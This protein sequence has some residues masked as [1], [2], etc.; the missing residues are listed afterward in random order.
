MEIT[1][2]QTVL[3]SERCDALVL[4]F[5]KEEFALGIRGNERLKKVCSGF[6]ATKDF[7][8]NLNETALLYTQEALAAKRILFVGLGEV[9][10]Y[11]F[12]K[13][14]QAAG[15]AAKTLMELGVKRLALAVESLVLDKSN[16]EEAAQAAVEGVV[17]ATYQYTNFKEIKPEDEK[18]VH[19]VAYVVESP[20]IVQ[21]VQQGI[22]RGQIVANAANFARDLQNHP[23]NWATP[24]RLAEIAQSTAQEVG[25][26]CQILEKPDMERLGM[27]AFLGVAQGSQE[28]PK[29]IIL[30]H[31]SDQSNLE[32]VVFVGKGIT[33]DSGGISIKPSEKMQEMKFD[34]SGGAAVMGALKATAQL[35]IPLHVVGLIPATENLP[36]GTSMKPGDILRTSSGT[37]IEIVNTDAE[38]RLILADALVYAK[39]YKPKAV[40]DLATLT[41]SCV[42]ALGHYATG[43]FG[44]DAKILELLKK[45]G[46]KTG[47]R[48]W[49][50]PL[51]D[52]YNEDIKSDYADVKNSGGRWGGAITAAAFLAKFAKD[53]PWAHLDIAG[54]AWT[55]KEKAYIPKGGTG[56]GVRLLVQFLRDWVEGE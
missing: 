9:E 31:N 10:H 35:D 47:E 55:D 56:M 17:L 37:T 19:E 15:T 29:F 28:P 23:G 3:E 2:K 51:W 13:L 40:V 27:G 36:S 14:R 53:Y 45:A 39:R 21:A 34:M 42:V 38:G 43:L 6:L 20:D 30:E 16:P 8:G 12:E 33:F 50:L 1:H 26:K 48:L 5:P 44:K 46:E 49:E 24:T 11:D 22:S 25:L 4:G 7:K 52:D 54:T 18:G 32:T 41:G